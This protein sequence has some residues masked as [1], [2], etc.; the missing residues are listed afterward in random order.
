MDTIIGNPP[1][2]RFQDILISTKNKLLNI[3]DGRSNLSLF[4]IWRAIDFLNENGELIFLVPTISSNLA[5]LNERLYMQ[6]V[7]HIGKNMVTQNF[8]NASPNVAIF[9]WVKRTR[10]Y[11]PVSC[12]NGFK[13][14]GKLIF[15]Q[16]HFLMLI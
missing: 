2:I 12:S 5:P 15:G 14:G 6:E 11:T 16:N 13:V 3:L 4:S 8:K 7:L 1:Y 9:R 10:T